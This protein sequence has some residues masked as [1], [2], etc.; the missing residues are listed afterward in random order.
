MEEESIT[1]EALRG[2]LQALEEAITTLKA[3][4]QKYDG[5]RQELENLRQK[6]A[7]DLFEERK[8]VSYWHEQAL[9]WQQDY[10][11]LR[12]QKG[13]FGFH[14]LSA[15]VLAAMLL[16]GLAMYLFLKW[17]DGRNAAFEAFRREQLFK[18]EFALSHGEYEQA[19]EALRQSLQNPEYRLAYPQIHLLEEV[20]LAA[21]K[22]R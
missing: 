13:G 10:E 1:P 4:A 20:V 22:G 2:R 9:R 12:I 17:T 11:Q 14:T 7:D 5:F 6:Y 21:E 19:K 3:R 15:V 16:T 18:I 8:Q